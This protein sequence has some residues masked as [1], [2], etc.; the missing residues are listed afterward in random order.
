MLLLEIDDLIEGLVRGETGAADMVYGTALLTL[1]CMLWLEHSESVKTW[2]AAI[3]S[4]TDSLG[5]GVP[6]NEIN[7]FCYSLVHVGWEATA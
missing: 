2:M 7:L 6:E 5:I 4:G 1:C 3:D